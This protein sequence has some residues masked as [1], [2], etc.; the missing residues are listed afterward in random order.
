M[1]AHMAMAG[2]DCGISRMRNAESKPKIRNPH[3]GSFLL[4]FLCGHIYSSIVPG[5]LMKGIYL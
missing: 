1:P 2:K 5:Q 3:S 4:A